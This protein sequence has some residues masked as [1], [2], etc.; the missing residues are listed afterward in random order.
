MA[1]ALSFIAVAAAF[2]LVGAAA[3]AKDDIDALRVKAL[4]HAIAKNGFRGE[5][6]TVTSLNVTQFLGRWYEVYQDWIT[7]NTFQRDSYCATADYGIDTAVAGRITVAN[8]EHQGSITGPEVN[9]SGYAYQPDPQTYPGR[10]VVYLHGDHSSPFPAPYWVLKLGP[11]VDGKYDYAVVSDNFRLTLFV[12][13][14]DVARFESTYASS[15]L[16]WL[17]ANGFTEFWNKPQK[18]TQANCTY[19]PF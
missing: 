11:V 15:V 12:L 19:F 13:A 1:R 9:V 7:A 2:L 17:A 4:E 10:L 18:L 8:K 16:A 3:T 5:P 6:A 14:R